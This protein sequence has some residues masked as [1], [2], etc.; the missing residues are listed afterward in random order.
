MPLYDFVCEACGHRFESYQHS[1]VSN[2]G[3]WEDCPECGFMAKRRW[4]QQGIAVHCFKGGYNVGLGKNIES[5]AQEREE[6]RKLN[7]ARE[8]EF[9]KP[10]DIVC[11]G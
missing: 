2:A 6:I 9:G 11:S 7:A 10:S 8:E 3:K 4:A 1:G 5:R